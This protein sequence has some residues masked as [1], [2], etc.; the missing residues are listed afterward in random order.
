VTVLSPRA[1]RDDFFTLEHREIGTV[2]TCYR[3][4]TDFA[5]RVIATGFQTFTVAVNV[6][7]AL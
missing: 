2:K 7:G 4:K 1:S 5:A 3:S 6:D